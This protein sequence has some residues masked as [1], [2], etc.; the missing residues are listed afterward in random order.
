MAKAHVKKIAENR[1]ARF[2]Y[3]IED[4]FEAGI[5]LQGTEVKSL[6]QG[7]ANLKDSYAKV[8]QGEIFLH[9]LHISPYTHAHYDNHDPQRPRKLLLHNY[10]IKR[11]IGKINERGYTLIPLRLYFK[12]G[13]VKVTLAL[14]KGKKTV[15]KRETIR[16]RD[17]N[18]EMDRIRKNMKN[19]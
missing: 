7:R 19:M 1:K 13:K 14:G 15:D 17:Q 5:V 10:E 9:Q 11:L 18:R 12:E 6:R 8:R 2:N 16:Q 3:T 4:E